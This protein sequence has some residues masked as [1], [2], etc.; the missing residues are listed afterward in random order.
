MSWNEQQAANSVAGQRLRGSFRNAEFIVPTNDLEFGRRTQVH[1]FPLR[2][3]PYVEDL[4]RKARR[5][6]LEV[7]VAGAGY[8]AA[9]DALIA[10]IEKPGDGLLTHP[11]Y[12]ILNVTVVDAKVRET[13][14]EG[15]K[16]TFNIT[17]VEAGEEIFPSSETDTASSTDAAATVASDSAIAAFAKRFSVEGLTGWSIA[18]LE[19]EV[20]STLAG[21][22]KLV[23]DVAGTISAEIRAPYNMAGL[24]VG[25]IQQ[26]ATLAAEP[27]EALRL[28]KGLFDSGAG[29]Q[30]IPTTT[31]TRRQQA[32]S[33]AALQ[34]LTRASSVIEACRAASQADFAASDDALTARDDLLDAIEARMQAVD[35]V[36]GAPIDSALFDALRSLRAAMVQDLRVRGAKLP[37]ITYYTPAAALPA[38]VLAYRIYGDASRAEELVARNNIRHPGFVPGGAALEVLTDA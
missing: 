19:S 3:K 20:A 16:A 27:F 37:R 10:E 14:R 28:Y 4:G 24:I 1:E 36:T 17:F 31:A 22:T 5:F 2:E 18:A 29:S 6:T 35:P 12:G 38:R 11:Y 13:S 7:F 30:A 25:S 33:T 32:Q 21:V 26:I 8:M 34:E 15:G 23:G 9:R